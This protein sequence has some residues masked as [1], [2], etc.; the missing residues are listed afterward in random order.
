MKE[1]NQKIPKVFISSTIDDLKEYRTA[2]AE[3]IASEDAVPVKSEYWTAS[4]A[5][6][7]VDECIKR[8]QHCDVLVVIVA[9][10]Y[11]WEPSDN[12]CV[13]ADALS[14]TWI[15]CQAAADGMIEILPFL[16]KSQ[17]GHPK[18]KT[19]LTCCNNCNPVMPPTS[20]FVR[21]STR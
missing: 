14:I 10:R 3:A 15:E 7:P 17:I 1:P 13:N 19:N 4:G 8:I 16:S 6:P 21:H 18:R 12:T 20:I 2:A 9:Y 11:G 5:R